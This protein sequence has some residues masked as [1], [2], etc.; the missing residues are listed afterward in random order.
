MFKKSLIIVLVLI[1]AAFVLAACGGSAEP[2]IVEVTR[3]VTETVVETVEGEPV[4][5]EVT[6]VV[7]ETVEVEVPVETEEEAA[8]EAGAPADVYKIALFEDPVSGNNYWN[9]LGPGSSVWTSYVL[10]GYAASLFGLSDQ[11]FDF[12]PQLAKD[13][14]EPV[15]N[16]DGTYTMT[17]EMVEDATWSDG[18]PITAHDVAFTHNACKD[19]NLTQNWPNNCQPLGADVTAEAIGDYTVEYTFD[20]V[21]SL[22]VWN[23]GVALAPILPEHFW[24]DTIA[25]AYSFIDGLEAPVPPEG[26]EDCMAEELSDADAETCAPYLEAQAAYDEAF[27]NARTIVYEADGSGSPVYGGFT[28]DQFEP[29]AFVQ[30]TA[31][32]GYYFS[33]S[34]IVEYDDGTWMLEHPN[35][36]TYQLYGDATGDVTLDFTTGPYVDNIILSIYGSQD[37]AF[38][39]L[40]DGEVDY[41][42]NPLGLSRGLK[43]QA[44]QSEGVRT[45]TNADYGMYYLAFNMR[46][47]PMSY[48]EFRQV[49]DILLD[50][51]FVVNS[52]LAGVV[53]P[54]YST[55][56]PGNAFWHNPDVPTPYVGMERGERLQT[57]IDLLESNGWTWDTKP[58]WDPEDSSAENVVPGEGLRMPT[59]ELV[60]PL[61]ILGPGPA[62]D[63]LRAT[64][65]QWISEW[66][67]E[68]GIPVE[69]ELTGF[70][71]I[72]DPVFINSDFDMYILGWSLGNVAFPDYYESFW[73]SRNDTAV[74]GNYNT[75][76]YNDPDY[77]AMVDEFMET[78]D[79]ARAK[80]LVF[81]MQVKLA[82]DRPYIPLFYKQV[83]DIVRSNVEFPYEETL[84]GIET[85][86]GFQTDAH[87]FLTK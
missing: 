53:Y 40:A 72:L 2:Q 54:M 35:G 36:T 51:E 8:P 41:V 13:L 56:P 7:T 61:T 79:L 86:G 44:Q 23:A 17:V 49:V 62:Y 85:Q 22:G 82:E 33:G 14:V 78:T 83:E 3:V 24:G 74:S 58:Q 25:E 34:R 73:H 65:N 60:P 45:I 39:A 28:T 69:S 46:K 1:A 47:E 6:R 18:E 70:N 59:G 9:Y 57:A 48:P 64:F 4:E 63:P 87:V 29:G 21:P 43:E 12:I 50:K 52:V 55:M 76:G 30:R 67:R 81:E 80:E 26:V 84:G 19:L 16:G 27:V 77:D 11:R 66:S 10:N 32:P 31:N 71:T 75:P 37:A 20:T 38:L 5:V 68:L 15:D 42:L